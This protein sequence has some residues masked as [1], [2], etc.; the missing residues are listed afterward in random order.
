MVQCATN[1][2]KC[3][4]KM[5]DQYF[6]INVCCVVVCLRVSRKSALEASAPTL[7]PTLVG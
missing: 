6:S 2:S 1:I 7:A 5:S 3:T 4:F